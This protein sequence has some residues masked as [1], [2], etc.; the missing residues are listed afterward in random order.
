MTYKIPISII[1]YFNKL[2]FPF[3]HT[4]KKPLLT[5][6]SKITIL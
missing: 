1:T 2:L 5:G 4:K 3:L 6:S